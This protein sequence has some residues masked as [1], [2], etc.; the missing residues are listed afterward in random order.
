MV[1]E[2]AHALPIFAAF[3]DAVHAI[4]S[5]AAT[6][7]DLG[8]QLATI[9]TIQTMAAILEAGRRSLDSSGRPQHLTFDDDG[10]PA[11]IVAG[12]SYP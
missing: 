7:T 3:I 4:R 6:P 2:G 11:S 9:A 10:Q 8:G 1:Y 12:P 5:G